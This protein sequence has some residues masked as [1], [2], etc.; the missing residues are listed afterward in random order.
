MRFVSFVVAI[1]A[2]F[3]KARAA[4]PK[5]IDFAHDV[6]PILK[7]RCAK[8]HTNGTYKGSISFDTRVD[9]VKKAVIPGKSAMSK[10]IQRVTNKDTD[11]RMPPEGK[12]LDE[13]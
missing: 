6:V 9:I 11:E 5:P 4:D 10:L 1:F 7:A 12:P 3:S 13:K 8:C 2:L